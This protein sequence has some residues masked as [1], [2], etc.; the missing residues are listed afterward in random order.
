MF[1]D[2]LN[3]LCIKKRKKKFLNRVYE[4]KL[5][6]QYPVTVFVFLIRISNGINN[7]DYIL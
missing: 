2:D 1:L 6:F 7:F 3:R 5:Y 4:K